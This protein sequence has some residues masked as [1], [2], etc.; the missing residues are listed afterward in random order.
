MLLCT[1]GTGFM[2]KNYDFRQELMQ[3]HRSGLRAA[4]TPG[5]DEVSLE[6]CTICLHETAGEVI[7]TAAM[8]FQDYLH[9]SMGASAEVSCKIVSGMA[10][11]VGTYTQLGKVWNYDEVAASYEITVNEEGITVCGYDDRGCAQGLY[12]LE[13]RMNAIRAPYLAKGVFH[14][15]PA[16]S[17]RMVHSGYG[18]EQYPDPYLSAI[19]HAGMDAILLFV[20]GVDMTPVGPLD[21]NDIIARA[22]RYGLD[23]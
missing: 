3:W 20:S 11:T 18:Q 15:A 8:D 10:V 1:K 19:A 16:F 14:Y 4:Y 6:K 2:E 17:P 5:K 23:V 13:D 7:S 21:F 9:T 22:A 12:Q